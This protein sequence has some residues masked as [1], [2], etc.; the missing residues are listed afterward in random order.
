MPNYSD[1]KI[2]QYSASQVFDLVSDIESYPDFLPWCT[3]AT[4]C[5]SEDND[6]EADLEIGYRNLSLRY[7]SSVKLVRP[8]E[9]N[10]QSKNSLTPK[11]ITKLLA[12]KFEDP[13]KHLNSNW[14][15]R[16]INGTSC[17]IIFSIDF[18]FNSIH[19]NLLELMIDSFF[20]RVCSEM[21][22]SFEQ[23]ASVLYDH[24]Q[25]TAK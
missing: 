1:T 17:E 3:A 25:E 16:E 6:V 13:F 14:K 23:R 24:P 5:R 11:N 19:I 22:S 2:V 10:I 7:K 18:A 8:T 21:V 15:F 4:I 20:D 9:I 12:H